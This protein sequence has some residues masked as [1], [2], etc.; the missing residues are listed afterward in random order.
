MRLHGFITQGI[1]SESDSVLQFPGIEE[2]PQT[3]PD[4][5]ES[6]VEY[7]ESKGDSR[8][9]EIKKVG[10]HWPRLELVDAGYKGMEYHA[11][12]L[13]GLM[14]CWQSSVNGWSHPLQSFSS[15]SNCALIHH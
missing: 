8:A 1:S 4:S 9:D 15:F 12:S 6:L 7:L 10:Q 11:A 5:L 13:N 14:H 2:D 3:L